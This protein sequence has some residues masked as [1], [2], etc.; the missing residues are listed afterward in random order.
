MRSMIY[1][2]RF[3]VRKLGKIGQ[4]SYQLCLSQNGRIKEKIAS[5]S[6]S[7]FMGRKHLILY[8]GK[9][10]NFW[11]KKGVRLGRS[12]IAKRIAVIVLKG[13]TISKK[14]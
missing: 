13:A 5:V 8:R 10:L 7:T 2:Y 3:A 1:P 6:D 9:R 12:T 11:M 14:R 4:R